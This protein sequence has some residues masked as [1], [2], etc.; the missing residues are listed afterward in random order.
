MA[1]FY[2]DIHIVL[3][4]LDLAERR[5]I[6][7]IEFI[8]ELIHSHSLFIASVEMLQKRNQPKF[9]THFKLK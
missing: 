2:H 4:R 3:H 5:Y 7:T 8:H 9:Y 6:Y 1:I